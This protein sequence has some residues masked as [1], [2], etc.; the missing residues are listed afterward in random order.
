LCLRGYWV[1]AGA[2]AAPAGAMDQCARRQGQAPPLATK[3]SG[4]ERRVV[5]SVVM[6]GAVYQAQRL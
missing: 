5:N 1:K 6:A 2:V 4:A 3:G